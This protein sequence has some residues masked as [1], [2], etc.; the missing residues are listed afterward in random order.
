METGQLNITL[1]E[2]VSQVKEL[3]SNLSKT[4]EVAKST[5][6]ST[7]EANLSFIAM[8]K[9]LDAIGSVVPGLATAMKTYTSV[10]KIWGDVTKSSAEGGSKA[11]NLFNKSLGAIGIIITVCATLFQAIKEKIDSSAEATAKFREIMAKL[12]PIM[13]IANK[14]L[15]VTV[16]VLLKIIDAGAT[17]VNWLGKV[18]SMNSK[19]YDEASKKAQKYAKLANQIAKDEQK[20]IEERGKSEARQ[21]KLREQIA[22]ADG[23][24][25]IKLLKQL[26]EEIKGQTD[27]AIALNK[28]RIALMEYQQSLG[29]T[30]E[31]EKKALAEL[32]AATDSLIGEQGRQI[33]KIDK[34]IKATNES[35]KTH[36]VKTAKDTKD[37]LKKEQQE[38]MKERSRI[39][40]EE[41]K[42]ESNDKSFLNAERQLEDARLK[43]TYQTE[44][45]K[46]AIKRS[47]LQEDIQIEQDNY[48]KQKAIYEESIASGK[49]SAEDLA[50]VKMDLETLVSQHMI[51]ELNQQTQ[52]YNIQAEE[53]TNKLK[54]ELQK[55]K[56]AETIFNQERE[57]YEQQVKEQ[58]EAEQAL[59][60]ETMNQIFG[61]LDTVMSQFDQL[62]K[63]QQML[64]QSIAGITAN[65]YSEVKAF[66]DL[67]D[68]QQ[69]AANKTKLA[70]KVIG[71]AT[72]AATQ[73]VNSFMDAKQ[74]DIQEDLKNGKITE[75]QAK[76]EFEKT[77]KVKIAMAVIGMAQGIGEA[78]AGAM[79]LGPIAGPIIGAINSAM[80]AASGALQIKNIK[81]TT[82]ES[83]GGAESG[84]TGVSTGQSISADTMASS[85][86]TGVS[87]NPLLN[88]EFD[89]ASIS[90]TATT[91][92]ASATTDQR[93]YIVEQDIQDS[94][95]R[96]Q[97]RENETTF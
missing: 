73:I 33:A 20:L 35:V 76:K 82:L 57:A 77:K 85:F 37:A 22:N 90:Q 75:E 69:N 26:K 54:E 48:N 89:L 44:D 68:G 70:M 15:E 46:I 65:V 71:Q 4:S 96:V 16:D 41:L 92:G 11:M 95:K 24:T 87:A 49:L 52:T 28:K 7:A 13:A 51:N 56:E 79:S 5:K 32:K 3:N 59:R 62:N 34:Q 64:M 8:Q 21:G 17:A 30:S 53:Q 23:A 72:A 83:A 18:F 36:T 58:E 25:K 6:Q 2:L 38:Y 29:P 27:A 66:K 10:T 86:S 93:V 81:K 61:T 55:R 60:E 45:Q 31:A 63:P 1:G 80:V 40:Q 50:K 9:S 74:K 39:I 47:R 14:A 43:L 19:S 91:Q 67:G 88:E 84:D 97:I 12:E 94:N 78:I 42:R